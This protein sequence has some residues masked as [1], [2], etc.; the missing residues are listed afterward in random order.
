VVAGGRRGEDDRK[1]NT[2][3]SLGGKESSVNLV[4]KKLGYSGSNA[5][6]PCFDL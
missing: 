3:A 2:L 1:Q 5:K 4:H 6:G